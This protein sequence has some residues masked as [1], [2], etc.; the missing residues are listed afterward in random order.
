M[1]LLTPGPVPGLAIHEHGDVTADIDR[2][3]ASLADTQRP[4]VQFAVPVA[5]GT[6]SCAPDESA[7]AL[8]AWFAKVVRELMLARRA[9]R[10]DAED[11]TMKAIGEMLGAVE[12]GNYSLAYV[13][14]AAAN[15][16]IKEQMR[17]GKRVSHRLDDP[18]H[19]QRTEGV[20][21]RRLSEWEGE[22]W[23]EDVLSKLPPRQREVM[24][25]VGVGLGNKE[26][27]RELGMSADAVRR[28]RSDARKALRKLLLPDGEYRRPAVPALVLG[29]SAS[30]A[31]DNAVAASKSLTAPHRDLRIMTPCERED[32][33]ARVE[34]LR[35]LLLRC[36]AAAFGA[37][38]SAVVLASVAA[39][40]TARISDRDEWAA[41]KLIRTAYPHLAFAGCHPAAFDVQRARAE[42]LCELGYYRP[43]QSLLHGLSEEERQVFGADNPRTALLLLW[44]Q[45]MSGEFLQAE[46]GFRGL[47]AR[48]VQSLGSGTPLLWHVQCRRCWLLGKCGQAGESAGGYDGV[49]FNRSRKLGSGHADVLDAQHSKAKC[50]SS[51]EPEHRRS[52]SCGPWPMTARV[53][54]GTTTPTR[55]K[56]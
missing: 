21:D 3:A 11:A 40:A 26:I 33:V 4:A 54:K 56:P 55:W 24:E 39:M 23:W 41:L 19:N 31:A 28:N 6:R 10:H 16:F 34:E 25:C 20:A 42:A 13:R 1:E 7:E 9:T 46:T 12:P 35:K 49:V 29:R 17:Y 22:R 37:A 32:T 47:E 44:A 50:S 51:A 36:P 45:A 30:R 15:N 18:S 2:R 8:K 38:G 14:K 53:S 27:A 52:R 43:A 5:A 48:L